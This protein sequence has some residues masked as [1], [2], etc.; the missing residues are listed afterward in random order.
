MKFKN[1]KNIC[2]EKDK[3]IKEL[4]GKFDLIL[5]KL[6]E[7]RTLAWEDGCPISGSECNNP[8]CEIC[9]VDRAIEIVKGGGVNE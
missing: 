2:E 6:K 9:F 7:L 5:E 8:W 4:E 3:R 1:W